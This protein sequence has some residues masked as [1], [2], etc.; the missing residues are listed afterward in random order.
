MDKPVP[1][2]FGSLDSLCCSV[3]AFTFKKK[4]DKKKAVNP[5]VVDFILFFYLRY[6]C[7]ELQ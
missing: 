1:G 3:S 7:L 6:L 5:F 4:E 2:G